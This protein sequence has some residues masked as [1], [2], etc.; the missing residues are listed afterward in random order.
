MLEDIGNANGGLN[1]GLNGDVKDIRKHVINL[2]AENS[3]ITTEQIANSLKTTKRR[4]EYH[5]NQLKNAGLVNR[6]G[7]KKTGHWVVKSGK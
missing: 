6:I 5:I 3:Q 2:L 1:G 4:I 7:S